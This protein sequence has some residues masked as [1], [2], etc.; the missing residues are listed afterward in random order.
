MKELEDRQVQEDED[1]DEGEQGG[2][3]QPGKDEDDQGGG[4]EEDPSP[5]PRCK[6]FI[7]V[8]GEMLESLTGYVWHIAVWGQNY[9]KLIHAEMIVSDDDN[10]EARAKEM[11]ALLGCDE[12]SHEDRMADLILDLVRRVDIREFVGVYAFLMDV[13]NWENFIRVH[14]GISDFSL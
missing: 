3:E 6:F 1:E 13:G 12:W 2:G 8:D 4:E 7:C 11:R 10:K 14:C 5:Y 9:F